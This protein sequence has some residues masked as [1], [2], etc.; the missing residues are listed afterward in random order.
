MRELVN[1]TQFRGLER[2][3]GAD[4]V[5]GLVGALRAAFAFDEG[6]RVVDFLQ[7]DLM[8]QPL[9]PVDLLIIRDILFH[10]RTRRA[11]RDVPFVGVLGRIDRGACRS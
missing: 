2:Y 1:T 10:F 9:F 7:F 11:A 4:V 8:A 6:A 5:P 3:Y